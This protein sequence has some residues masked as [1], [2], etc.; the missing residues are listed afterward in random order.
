[1]SPITYLTALRNEYISTKTAN[2]IIVDDCVNIWHYSEVCSIMNDFVKTLPK[3][4]RPRVLSMS[5]HFVYTNFTPIFVPTI[6]ELA[7]L[8]DATV[9][10]TKESTEPKTYYDITIDHRDNNDCFFSYKRINIIHLRKN[11]FV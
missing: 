2:I 11:Q 10:V 6:P 1:M 7:A 5:A 8:F 9:I 3:S 4:E